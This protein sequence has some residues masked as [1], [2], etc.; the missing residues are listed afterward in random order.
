LG[1]AFFAA[2]FFAVAILK[3]SLIKLQTH[4]SAPLLCGNPPPNAP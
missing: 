3:I 1:A 2:G 4:R